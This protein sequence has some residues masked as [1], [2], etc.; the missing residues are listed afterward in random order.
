M[1]INLSWAHGKQ[2]VPTKGQVC[3]VQSTKR[4]CV[5]SSLHDTHTN[6]PGVP[7]FWAMTP[8]FKGHG[9]SRHTQP[10]HLATAAAKARGETP[11]Y[12]EDQ[13]PLGGTPCQVLQV[14]WQ[15]GKEGSLLNTSCP[16]RLERGFCHETRNSLGRCAASPQYQQ[17][18]PVDVDTAIKSDQWG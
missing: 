4:H 15:R 3:S 1:S 5:A 11:K 2:H 8:F 14:S 18:A 7:L 6:T 10:S 13:I 16:L 17:L 9:D 12:L